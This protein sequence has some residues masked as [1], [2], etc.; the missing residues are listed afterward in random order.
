MFRT[1]TLGLSWQ[2]DRF[3]IWRLKT[4]G[5]RERIYI[6]PHLV[7]VALHAGLVE[8]A[9]QTVPVF[10]RVCVR[11]VV[12]ASLRRCTQ[13]EQQLL[14][15]TADRKSCRN[16]SVQ[17]APNVY[18]FGRVC[19]GGRGGVNC[20]QQRTAIKRRAASVVLGL[21]VLIGRRHRPP[22]RYLRAGLPLVVVLRGVSGVG[23]VA[24]NV[25]P[26]I[27]QLSRLM[28]VPSLSW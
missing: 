7:D 24:K 11:V 14:C 23:P 4:F 6:I 15:E 13:K 18:S 22:G 16:A 27:C 20:R 3:L 19:E 9:D 25:T 8:V 2:A 10:V 1:G 21:L 12:V 17:K 28:F 26:L 5:N